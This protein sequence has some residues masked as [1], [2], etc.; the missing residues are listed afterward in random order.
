MRLQRAALAHNSSRVAEAA[1]TSYAIGLG[2][3]PEETG[4]HVVAVVAEPEPICPKFHHNVA[5]YRHLT[6][7][8]PVHGIAPCSSG[9]TAA[10]R[11]AAME[12]ER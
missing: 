3:D 2:S 9:T 12:H 5:G 4:M 10:A 1:V 7:A 8:C 6:R 11:S